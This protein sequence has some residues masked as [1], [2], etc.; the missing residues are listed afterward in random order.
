MAMTNKAIALS[1]LNTLY[2]VHVVISRK[3]CKTEMLLIQTIN[4]KW[5]MA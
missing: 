3:W 5:Y 1:A 2:S 4:T